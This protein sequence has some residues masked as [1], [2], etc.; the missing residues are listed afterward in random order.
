MKKYEATCPLGLNKNR[1]KSKKTKESE[2]KAMKRKEEAV[3]NRKKGRIVFVCHWQEFQRS[4]QK[5]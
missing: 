4:K 1:C 5:I 2:R 3:E